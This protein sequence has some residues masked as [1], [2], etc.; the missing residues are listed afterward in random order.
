MQDPTSRLIHWRLKLFEYEYNIIYKAR[1]RKNERGRLIEKS[2]GFPNN[3]I[4]MYNQ[5]FSIVGISLSDDEL[6]VIR[7]RH[8]K[9]REIVKLLET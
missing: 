7:E 2:G 9:P 8:L 1:K 3:K 5:I 6:Y 4:Y